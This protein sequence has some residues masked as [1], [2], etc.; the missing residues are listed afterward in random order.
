MSTYNEMFKLT[1]KD[2]DLIERTVRQQ[3]GHLSQLE[4]SP[5]HKEPETVDK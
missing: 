5:H 3:I 1:I 2:V 4:A